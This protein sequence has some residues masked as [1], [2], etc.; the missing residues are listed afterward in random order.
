MSDADLIAAFL[1]KNS[2]TRVPEGARSLTDHQ[3]K[4]ACGYEPTR[5]YKYEALLM[6]EDG[7]E[8]ATEITAMS[9]SRAKEILAMQYPESRVVSVEY[10]GTR[11][12]RLYNEAL[13]EEY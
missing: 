9:R 5:A 1:A 7:S 3:I 6:G 13:N 10:A 4:F 11:E 8:F 2:V 12:Q